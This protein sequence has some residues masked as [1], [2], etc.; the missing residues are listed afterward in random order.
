VIITINTT[1]AEV[2]PGLKGKSTEEI[3]TSVEVFA[4]VKKAVQKANK[5]LAQYE[6]IKKFKVLNRDFSIESGE[7]TPTMKVRRTKVLENFKSAIAEM[8]S[9][10][11]DL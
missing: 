5:Q 10:K 3:C 11:E 2:L 6:Q 9:A 8:Y 7:M 4:E 1:A